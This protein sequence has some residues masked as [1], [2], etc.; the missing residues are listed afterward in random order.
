MT[1]RSG[2][3]SSLEQVLKYSNSPTARVGRINAVGQNMREKGESEEGF[4]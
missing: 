2:R 1:L 3:I 4:F